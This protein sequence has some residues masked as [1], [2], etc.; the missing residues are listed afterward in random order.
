MLT[1]D[2]NFLSMLAFFVCCAAVIL[3]SSCEEHV[4]KDSGNITA[5]CG[6][7]NI[8]YSVSVSFVDNKPPRNYELFCIICG[9]EYVL[10]KLR[11]NGI[12][13]LYFGQVT[14]AEHIAWG[15][16]QPRQL[17]NLLEASVDSQRPNINLKLRYSADNDDV[18]VSI[19]LKGHQKELWNIEKVDIVLEYGL[20]A[21]GALV[22]KVEALALR[23]RQIET[24][25]KIVVGTYQG[26]TLKA[27]CPNGYV[28]VW[29]CYSSSGTIQGNTIQCNNHKNNYNRGTSDSILCFKA[30]S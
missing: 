29:S 17:V 18:Y 10:F 4:L 2:T 24:D 30:K 25:L 28:P 8:S 11:D 22:K 27:T 6:K 26:N 5:Q 20:T 3:G 13:A 16:A 14:M 19:S 9:N 15:I 1:G 12:G 23:T 21:Y 7:E